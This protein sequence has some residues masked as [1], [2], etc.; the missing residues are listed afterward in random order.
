MKSLDRFSGIR[1]KILGAL[2]CVSLLSTLAFTYHAY[3]I[4]RAEIYAGYE[5]Q[6]DV[7]ARAVPHLLPS[8]YH[9]RAVNADGINETEYLD[10]MWQATDW[11]KSTG[12][13]YVY[14]FIRRDGEIYFTF[15]S[16]TE[17]QR[18]E[19]TWVP[20]FEPYD[21][22]VAVR[23]L[24][25]ATGRVVEETEDEYGTFLSVLLPFTNTAGEVYV[26]GADVYLE[27]V[28]GKLQATVRNSMFIGIAI[29]AA[30][31]L[32][33]ILISG[34]VAR[35]IRALAHQT[36]RLSQQG[37]APDEEFEREMTGIA[38][39][40]GGEVGQ[41]AGA[42]T[43]MVTKLQDY[44]DHIKRFTA[45]KERLESELSIARN[46]QMS[47]LPKQF[48]PYPDRPE[49]DLYAMLEPAREVGG[50]L[51][52][53]AL[54]NEEQLFVCVGDVSG[55]GVPSALF[56]AVTK[57][58]FKGMAHPDWSPARIMTRVN[59]E[60]REHNEALMF[61]TVFFAILNLRTGE[62][63]YCNAGH[64]PPVLLRKGAAPVFL[65]TTPGFVLGVEEFEYTA[66]SIRLQP[67]DHLFLYTDGV[68]E[69]M[70]TKQELYGNDRLIEVLADTPHDSPRELSETVMASVHTY[71]KGEPQSDDVTVLD[72]VFNGSK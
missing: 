46:I 51:Y 18:A 6:L 60:L 9:D 26:A 33:G 32:V 27:E 8:D 55:K 34:R 62:L 40:A 38:E 14:N 3:V 30:L 35:P 4:Q 54:M 31:M 53:F 10:L 21:A 7:A 59:D 11:A 20:Y 63:D 43:Q 58:L 16:G 42:T 17:E 15:T 5:K 49:F 45:A 64:N 25:D 36:S 71:A 50:D 66:Q 41:L 1:F 29:F 2:L 57:T 67:G 52:D 22:S 70:N 13:S 44:I 56:M 28:R 72:V 39:H 65:D 69:A 23:G 12:V 48:P 68:T 24:F 19:G 47:F 61:V 37:F